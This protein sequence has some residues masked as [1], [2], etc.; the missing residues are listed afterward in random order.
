MRVS[1]V[2]RRSHMYLALF[3]TP[4]VVVYALSTLLFNHAVTGSEGPPISWVKE[5]ESVYSRTF[6]EG[7]SPQAMA[8]QILADLNLSGT[9]FA[10]LRPNGKL[11]I[12]RRDPLNPRR[13]TYTPETGTL[14]VERQAMGF[15][16]WLRTLHHRAGFGSPGDVLEN[17]WALSV[18]LAI[19]AMIFWAGSGIW[20]WWELRAAR[21]WGLAC[22]LAGIG[23]FAFLAFSL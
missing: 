8:D 19:L 16:T 3:F 10:N 9:R 22:A 7:T 12:N 1:V 17:S 14:L 21:K 6:P 2:I 15:P 11:I 18:D 23:I 5:S 20:M 13:L 4:W